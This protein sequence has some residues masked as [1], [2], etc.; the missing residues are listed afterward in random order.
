MIKCEP[1]VCA[2]I[3][4]AQKE[5]IRNTLPLVVL[6]GVFLKLKSR[7]RHVPQGSDERESGDARD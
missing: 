5:A 7:V 3:A 6:A 2:E 1:T 4:V